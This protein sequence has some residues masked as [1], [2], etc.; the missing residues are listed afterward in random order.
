[1]VM[2]TSSAIVITMMVVIMIV[3]RWTRRASRRS[4]AGPCGAGRR[5]PGPRGRLGRRERGPV[6]LRCRRL[7]HCAGRV[8][9]GVAVRGGRWGRRRHDA[10]AWVEA[11]GGGSLCK[12]A[13]GEGPNWGG[14][15]QR[16]S[17]DASDGGPVRARG[18]ARGRCARA[19]ARAR[20]ARERE[21]RALAALAAACFGSTTFG[22]GAPRLATASGRGDPT[23]CGDRLGVACGDFM[24]CGDTVGLLAPI[25][26]P[27]ASATAWPAAAL[28]PAAISRPAST[29]WL[30]AA[31]CPA[32]TL[33]L[34]WLASILWPAAAPW[35]G[36]GLRRPHGM[37]QCH[38]CGEP[39]SRRS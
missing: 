3:A 16:L 31:P 26:Q 22:F 4:R 34:G 6:V 20:M 33:R 8:A 18:A 9:G 36:Y 15:Q 37:R 38:G 19:G 39:I 17:R 7:P 11:A 30:A 28:C 1:M 24:A 10:R 35:C 2:V 23:A 21:A 5:R 13:S 14:P 12:W 27:S 25:L 29:Q 32:G